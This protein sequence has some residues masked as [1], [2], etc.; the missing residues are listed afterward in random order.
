MSRSN[1]PHG[2]KG[3]GS[4][5]DTVFEDFEMLRKKIHSVQRTGCSLVTRMHS[6]PLSVVE[7]D[8]RTES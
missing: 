7:W 2:K 1:K 3:P 4:Q 8:A 6:V 5:G